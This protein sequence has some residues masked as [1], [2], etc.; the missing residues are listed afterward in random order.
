[1]D[2]IES[3]ASFDA[4][5]AVVCR[6]IPPFHLEDAIVFD[7]IGE[8]ATHAAIGADGGDCLLWFDQ[9]YLAGRH[10]GPGGAGLH[11]FPAAHAGAGA[12]RIVQIEDYRNVRATVG[13]THDVVNLFFATGPDATR[14]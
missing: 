13:K 14:A 4:Q 12:H 1:M 7:Q 6:S 3:V 9:T 10:E 5:P 11:A 8:L 2:I